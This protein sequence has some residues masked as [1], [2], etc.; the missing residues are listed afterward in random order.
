MNL[1]ASTEVILVSALSEAVRIR[2][3][4]LKAIPKH[5]I[6]T[7]LRIGASPEGAESI[8][9]LF[10]F[11][12]DKTKARIISVILDKSTWVDDVENAI[13]QVQFAEEAPS[14]DGDYDWLRGVAIPTVLSSE[15]DVLKLINLLAGMVIR[16]LLDGHQ[17][18]ADVMH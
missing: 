17:P 15:K 5:H 3:A 14:E 6:Y 1:I 16:F 4:A 10:T 7:S 9:Q 12:V 18:T 8:A 11:E 13:V 2:V